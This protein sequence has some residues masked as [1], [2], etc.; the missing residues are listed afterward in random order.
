VEINFQ[1]G[2][3]RNVLDWEQYPKQFESPSNGQNN[4]AN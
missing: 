1:V 3:N 2:Y 4:L